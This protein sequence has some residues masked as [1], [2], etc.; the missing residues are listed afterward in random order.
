MWDGSN[1]ILHNCAANPFMIGDIVEF[2]KVGI[3]GGLNLYE[4][5]EGDDFDADFPC[6]NSWT[7]LYHIPNGTYKVV[8]ISGLGVR[9]YGN[10]FHDRWFYHARLSLLERQKKEPENDINNKIT[11]KIALTMD[12]VK[13]QW[14]EIVKIV[15]S[16]SIEFSHMLE[17]ATI[18]G[19]NNSAIIISTD[20]PIMNKSQARLDLA[21]CV[22]SELFGKSITLEIQR[23]KTR[24]ET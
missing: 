4:L 3:M 12:N 5:Y 2:I 11:S 16:A 15:K 21:N 23:R 19:I 22:I 9:I 24:N 13:A 1:R 10:G 14:T 20:N 7:P 6:L 17:M 8:E 18:I